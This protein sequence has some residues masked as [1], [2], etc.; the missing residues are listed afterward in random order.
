LSNWQRAHLIILAALALFAPSI[1]YA[2]NASYK[3][4]D[5]NIYDKPIKTQI[6]QF[7]VVSG[8]PTKAGLKAEIMRRYSAA[9]ARRGFLYHNPATNIYI[10]IYSTRKKALNDKSLWLGMVAKGFADKSPQVAINDDRLAALSQA[11]KERFGL[12]EAK[13][14]KVFIELGAA[15]D[16]ATHEA[17]SRISDSQLMKQIAL[18]R[19]LTKRYE[20]RL[21][22]KYHLTSDQ[23]TQI[24]VEGVKKGWPTR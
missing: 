18:E 17:M 16:R 14:K 2:G 3:I 11:P 7:I 5:E 23:M 20:T 1:L 22:H 21:A 24:A 12:S 15:D 10:Y 9:L 13:R 4:A 6:E 19:K 8:V